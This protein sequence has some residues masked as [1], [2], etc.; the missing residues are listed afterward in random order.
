MRSLIVLG[1]CFIF[2]ATLVGAPESK[3]EK[4]KGKTPNY[5][6]LEEGNEWKF[7]IT[8]NDNVDTITTRIAKVENINGEK[9]SRLEP[10]K[11][12][13]TEHLSQTEK[14]VFRN[15]LNG[16]EVSPALMLL[17]YPVK[18]GAKWAGEIT[19]QK[20]KLEY[21]GVIEAEEMVDVPAGKF[22]TLRVVLKLE[23]N[24]TEVITT[25][26]FAK[27]VGFVKQRVEVGGNDILLELEKH[28]GKK[29]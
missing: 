2:A 14:G 6:P 16:V 11:G 4:P 7:R 24:G 8:V 28:Q 3:K 12:E 9:L 21:T 17:P 23:E 27:D 10:S 18:V 5:Y 25:Y 22:K 26:W 1:V 19:V 13:I 20:K 15:R 29:R